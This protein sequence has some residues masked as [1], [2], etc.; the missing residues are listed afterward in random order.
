M[1][2][3]KLYFI[4]IQR[5]H[6][7]TRNVVE[8]VF[9]VWK[10]RFPVLAVGIRTK[11]STSMKTIVATAVLYN[12]LLQQRDEMPHNEEPIRPEFLH[13][14]NANPIRQTGNLVR[15]QLINSVFS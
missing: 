15:S 6:I 7:S 10:R 9:G 13:E 2:Q 12:I 3:V 8:R 5:A 1:M 4:F 11:L 14:L